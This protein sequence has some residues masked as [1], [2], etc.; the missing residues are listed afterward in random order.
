MRSIAA[1]LAFI[2]VM[3]LAGCSE[4]PAPPARPSVPAGKG[5]IVGTVTLAGPAPVM[6]EIPNSACHA[7][8]ALLKDE[9]VVA[10]GAGRL[11]NVVVAIENGPNVDVPSEP[12]VLDQ[13]N[14]RFS[15]H[16]VAVR[17]GQTLRVRS[18]DA[19][20]HNVH[21]M[22]RLNPEFNL[23]MPAA[24]ATKDLAFE[25]PE[26]FRVKCDVHP[27]MTGYIAVIDNPLFAV[28]DERGHF[29]I[30]NVPPGTY[31]LTA[32]H[33]RYG[34]TKTQVTVPPDATAEKPVAVEMSYQ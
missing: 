32:W 14:C 18:S 19:T 23:A 3:V 30:K 5:V 2:A 1:H 21:G 4:P 15:P 7:G 34:V 9:T 24:G 26:T 25:R 13:A 22:A 6:R 31:T 11:A 10:D 27:W 8:G 17:T 33:E 29:E 20:L 12:V 16:V 28:T